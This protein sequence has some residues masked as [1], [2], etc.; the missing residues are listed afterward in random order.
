MTDRTCT[1]QAG[2]F[3]ISIDRDHKGAYRGGQAMEPGK[4]RGW[5]YHVESEYC[6][7]ERIFEMLENVLLRRG[8]VKVD[9]IPSAIGVVETKP[10]KVAYF[11]LGD[12]N[13]VLWISGLKG[14]LHVEANK[15][16]AFQKGIL[17]KKDLITIF[18]TKKRQ[19]RRSIS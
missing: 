19:G 12:K 10:A 8:A 2:A 13:E 16:D 11:E 3:K 1:I 14:N 5:H 7:Q 15:Q 18:S 9:K 4:Y 17:T 6:S